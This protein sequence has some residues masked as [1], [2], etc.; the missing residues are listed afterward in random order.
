MKKI[1]IKSEITIKS[2][3]VALSEK[4]IGTI[5]FNFESNAVNFPQLNGLSKFQA[6]TILTISCKIFILLIFLVFKRK[7]LNLSI[8]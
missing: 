2:E 8:I 1:N 6:Q 3:E 7:M 4:N 5:L